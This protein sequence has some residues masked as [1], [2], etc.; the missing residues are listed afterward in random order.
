MLKIVKH[1]YKDANGNVWEI[2]KVTTPKKKG[3]YTCW[4]GDCV[5]LNVSFKRDTK[6][7]VREQIEAYVPA[8]QMNP[9]KVGFVVSAA[10]VAKH[11]GVLNAGTYIFTAH[12]VAL[13]NEL[14]R[15]K[16]TSIW[17]SAIRAHTSTGVPNVSKFRDLI[18]QLKSQAFD[19]RDA[20]AEII[21]LV[22]IK[23]LDEWKS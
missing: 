3:V 4:I 6:K 16:H 2:E 21:G 18:R 20:M 9:C 14:A 12:E 13:F 7:Q 23:M 10:D 11:N 8:G 17:G 22:G 1:I 15:C 19:N 5:A